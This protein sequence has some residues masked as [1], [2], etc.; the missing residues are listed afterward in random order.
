[1]AGAFIAGVGGDSGESILG[2][3]G[4]PRRP[5]LISAALRFR[6]VLPAALGERRSFP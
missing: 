4:G 5:P 1:M 6:S 2:R 3:G